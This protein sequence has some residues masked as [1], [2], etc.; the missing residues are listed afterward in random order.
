MISVLIVDN[1]SLVRE[2]LRALLERASDIRVVSEG[3]DGREA[4]D[5]TAAY[6]PDVV[7]MDI[8]MPRMNGLQATRQIRSANTNTRVIIVSMYD[9][10]TLL[11]QALYGG[12]SGF[13]AKSDSF[14]ELV[15]AVHAVHQGQTYLSRAISSLSS[16][17]VQ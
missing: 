16:G 7:L 12:A 3:R 8:R 13:V 17:A 9:E 15:D 14:S 4:I 11:D 5:L 1:D 6:D 10:E 2:G